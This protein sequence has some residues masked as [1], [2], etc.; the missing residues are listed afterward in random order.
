MKK[1]IIKW[2][3]LDIEYKLGVI[4]RQIDTLR[5]TREVKEYVRAE[6]KRLEDLINQLSGILAGLITYFNLDMKKELEDDPIY[7]K[8]EP[9]K[10][11]VYK[12][13]KSK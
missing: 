1:I 12:F 5:E 7:P 13:F 4:Q 6:N 8:P 2:L 3:G 11:E 10:R 9:K